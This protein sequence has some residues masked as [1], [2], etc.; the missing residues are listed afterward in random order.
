MVGG[1]LEYSKYVPRIAESLRAP[2]DSAGSVLKQNG[3]ASNNLFYQRPTTMSSAITLI[4][5]INVWIEL[6]CHSKH[7]CWHYAVH[8]GNFKHNTVCMLYADR[9]KN[10][11]FRNIYPITP[12]TQGVIPLWLRF[13]INCGN[14]CSF[15]SN[16]WQFLFCSKESKFCW[17]RITPICCHY[18]GVLMSPQPDHE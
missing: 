18:E 6:L 3:L 1:C 17:N 8:Y 9:W 2:I 5:K 14:N 10:R 11:G 13:C 7:Q 16:W 15:W 4:M 12:V